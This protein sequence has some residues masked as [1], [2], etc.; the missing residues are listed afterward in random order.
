[1]S[2]PLVNT[3]AYQFL[4]IDHPDAVRRDL[5]RICVQ[6]KLLGTAT[7]APE[8]LNL[9]MAGAAHGIAALEHYLIHD[10]PFA[11]LKFQ[12]SPTDTAPFTRLAVKTRPALLS[13]QLETPVTDRR[14]GRP[15]PPRELRQWLDQGRSFRLLD[16]RNNFET[17]LGQFAQAEILALKHFRDLPQAASPLM[18]NSRPTVMYCTG[19]IRCEVGSSWLQEQGHSNVWQLEGGILNYFKQCQGAH[20]VGECFVFDD[21]LAINPSLRATYPTL[22]PKCQIPRPQPEFGPCEN[23]TEATTWN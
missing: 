20:W 3:T 6:Q 5:R 11:Q 1:M 2:Q 22:C 4:D 8:G 21:R 10:T 19:G 17:R 18:P 7:V 23:C 9:S 13:L 14:P 12:H 15:L 16:L